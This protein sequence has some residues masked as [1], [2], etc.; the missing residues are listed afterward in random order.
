MQLTIFTTV[1]T[2]LIIRHY[3]Q[4]LTHW[5]RATHICVSKLTIIASDNGLSPGRR[6]AIIWNNAGILSIGPLGTNF[7]EILVEINTFF[8][9][10]NAFENVVW[11]MAAILSRPQCV[12][13]SRNGRLFAKKYHPWDDQGMLGY[14]ICIFTDWACHNITDKTSHNQNIWCTS[15]QYDISTAQCKKGTPLLMHLNYVSFLEKIETCHDANI[16]SMA[17]MEWVI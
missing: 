6:Q 8:I 7:S 14:S 15:Q 5:R 3:H 9:Q 4:S 10:E 12:K 16:A 2:W 1:A 11:K 17:A 13:L